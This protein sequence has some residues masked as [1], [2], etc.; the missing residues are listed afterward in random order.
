MVFL[1]DYLISR[2]LMTALHYCMG[3]MGGC[4]L[5]DEC[6]E[7]LKDWRLDMMREDGADLMR[8]TN[9]GDARTM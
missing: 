7:V 1:F 8:R 5:G 2:N 4:L 6:S 9:D 3:C